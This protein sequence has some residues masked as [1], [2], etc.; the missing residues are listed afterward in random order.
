MPDGTGPRRNRA[1]AT[2]PANVVIPA[3]ASAASW[4]AVKSLVAHP[5]AC[6]AAAQ[7]REDRSAVEQ[8]RPAVA[9]AQPAIA[10][11]DAGCA[12]RTHASPRGARRRRRRKAIATRLRHVGSTTTR[13]PQRAYSRCTARSTASGSIAKPAG[14]T[15]RCR[16]VAG[17]WRSRYSR[18]A[19]RTSD[20][21]SPHSRR[22]R[23][24]RGDG[25]VMIEPRLREEID[26]P[27]RRRRIFG[28]ARAEDARARYAR[29][30]I[31]PA[32]IAQGSSV[33]V[34]RRSRSGD[35]CLARA[36]ASRSAA[37]SGVRRGIAAA[38]WV[39]Y[40]RARR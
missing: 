35:S 37:I 34:E 22:A 5:A 29:A 12:R 19:T 36:P 21:S 24:P 20:S 10:S 13:W 17:S 11:P 8:P 40:R 4:K 30:A 3:C 31:A 6:C 39:R 33:D 27:S 28:S 23:T 18:L 26:R 1:A 15:G 9:A 2:G 32:H 7:R 25:R 38:R 14:A 16:T